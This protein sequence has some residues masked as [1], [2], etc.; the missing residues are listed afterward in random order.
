MPY[1]FRN[2][3]P[4]FPP[5]GNPQLDDRSCIPYLVNSILAILGGLIIIGI[6][7]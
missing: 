5:S 7:G 3:N 6:T 1:P 4:E 2:R